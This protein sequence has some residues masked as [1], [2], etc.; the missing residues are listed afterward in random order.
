MVDPL[1]KKFIFLLEVK[2]D[3]RYPISLVEEIDE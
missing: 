2:T 1:K 3:L